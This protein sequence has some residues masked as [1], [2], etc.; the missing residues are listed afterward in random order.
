MGAEWLSAALPDVGGQYAPTAQL[1][2]EEQQIAVAERLL[3]QQG[4]GAWPVCGGPLSGATPRN[5]PSEA[6]APADAP[7]DNPGLN[8]AARCPATAML[9]ARGASRA[10]R[11]EFAGFSARGCSQQRG[12][13]GY[14][15]ACAFA[16]SR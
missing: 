6:P 9:Q 16:H 11:I 14:L 13:R 8:N 5:V 1:A 3:A 4:R 2:T 12:R 10:C 15:A 7:L